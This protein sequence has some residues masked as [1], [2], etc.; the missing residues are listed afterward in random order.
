[1][2]ARWFRRDQREM[3]R[4]KPETV[5]PRIFLSVVYFLFSMPKEQHFTLCEVSQR[6]AHFTYQIEIPD[7][8][9]EEKVIAEIEE[10]AEELWDSG[11]EFTFECGAVVNSCYESEEHIEP[12]DVYHRS[13]CIGKK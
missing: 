12:Q 5:S 3:A 4:S 10:C 6:S 2:T 7:G 11:T 8:V 13:D 1:M 9:T